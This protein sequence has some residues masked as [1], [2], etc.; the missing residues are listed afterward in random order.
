MTEILNFDVGRINPPKPTELPENL[1]G[2]WDKGGSS[3]EEIEKRKQ[4]LRSIQKDNS[5]TMAEWSSTGITTGAGTTTR[6]FTTPDNKIAHIYCIVLT[7]CNTFASPGHIYMEH[8]NAAGTLVNQLAHLMILQNNSDNCVIT[9]NT[10]YKV[11]QG[12]FMSGLWFNFKGGA[13]Y[14]IYYWLEDRNMIV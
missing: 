9:L 11:D 1:K 4:I 2:T 12:E 7:G 10:P 14:V 8:R 3:L 5:T 6:L 13:A